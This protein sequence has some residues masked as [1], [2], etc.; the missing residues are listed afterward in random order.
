M[1]DFAHHSQCMIAY[2][3][4]FCWRKIKR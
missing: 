1:P 3:Y 4:S 2:W